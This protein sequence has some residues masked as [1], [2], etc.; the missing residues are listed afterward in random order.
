MA[1]KWIIM[2]VRYN[3]FLF[4]VLLTI[5]LN[6]CAYRPGK[7]VVSD[8]NIVQGYH[9][10]WSDEFETDGRPNQKN[11]TYEHGF[12]RNNELQWYQPENAF[13]KDGMLIIEAKR[14]HK[15]NP[16]FVQGSDDWK[17]SRENITYTSACLI[18]RGLQQFQYGRFEMRGRINIDKGLWPAFWTLGVKNP[19][20]ANGEIDI[21]E[22]YNQTLLANIASA[23]KDGRAKW[24]SNTKAVEE[25]GGKEWASKFHVW[26]M[27]W[28]KESINLFVDGDLMNKTPLSELKNDNGAGFNPF[29]Q[30]HYLLLNLAIGGMNGGDPSDTKFPKRFEIDY[31]RVYQK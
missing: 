13:C 24:F 7:L 8:N 30:A 25:L 11:W 17:K 22:Y 29:N 10:V 12:V 23:N 26:R 16:N 14:A 19:W 20:P 2:T 27:D 3:S 4:P 5:L 21:M 15:A 1:I 31:V 18:T 6:S 9:L 28:D